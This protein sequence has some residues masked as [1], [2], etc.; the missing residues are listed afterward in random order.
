MK[1]R[2]RKVPDNT[3]PRGYSMLPLLQ[4]RLF[5]GSRY[6]DVMCLIDSGAKDC[7]F[8]SSVADVLGIDI[9]TGREKGYYGI[10]AHQEV[11]GYL[12]TIQL[13]VQGFSELIEI[14]AAFTY[15]NQASL[16]GQVGFF[17]NYQVIFERYRGRFEIKSRSF[18]HTR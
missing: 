18:L 9:G 2:Y 10:A 3:D 1:F 4:V 8:H 6:T 5:H 11:T 13:Q 7:M 17:D 14:E 16:L 12:H 15:E